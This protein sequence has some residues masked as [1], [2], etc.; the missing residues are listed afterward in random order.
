VC[1]PSIDV[2]CAFSGLV[3]RLAYGKQ[4]FEFLGS[5]PVVRGAMILHPGDSVDHQPGK[6]HLVAAANGETWT[7]AHYHAAFLHAFLHDVDAVSTVRVEVTRPRLLQ[8]QKLLGQ[9]R[10]ARHGPETRPGT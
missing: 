10:E 8:R 7:L 6:L 5:R 4:R 1:N 3:Q 2:I 9:D